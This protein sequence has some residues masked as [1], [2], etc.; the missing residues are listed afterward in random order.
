VAKLFAGFAMSSP[1]ALAAEYERLFLLAQVKGKDNADPG[2]KALHE[3]LVEKFGPFRAPGNARRYYAESVRA[4]LKRKDGELK[5]LEAATPEYPRA[6]G[7]KEGDKIG[8][9]PIHIR[10]SHWTLGEKAPR[11]FLSALGGDQ[12][13]IPEGRSGRLE[14]AEWMTRPENPLTA[15]VIANRVWRWHFGRGIVPSVDNFGR[16]GEKPVNQPLLDWLAVEMVKNGWSLKQMHR[17]MMLT[18]TYQMSSTFDAK[19]AETDPDNTLLWRM[20]RRRLEA[21]SIRDGIME[22]SGGLDKKTTGGT[23]L[24]YKDRQYVANTSKGGDVDYDKPVRAVYIPV[25]RSSMYA[26]F[27]AFDLP[28]PAVSNGDRDSSVVAPQALFMMNGSVM[29]QHSKIMAE[30]L[31]GRSD[32]DDAGRVR[33]AYERA[34]SRPATGL[35]VDQALSFVAKMEAAWK[36]DRV[37]AWQSF[38]KS[39]LGSNEFI[40][41]N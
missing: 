3:L 17:T 12:V 21:E 41:I 6:M 31:L 13:T 33:E 16:L 37:R 35:A 9:L 19:A 4:E 15:R 30:G 22:V 29:L 2:L 14:M 36:G 32:L 18:S 24:K 25:V 23:I 34:L 10:G 20:N 28:D 39:L 38:C 27:T 7:V 5:A 40:Y 1:Q 26:M 8:D 11:R